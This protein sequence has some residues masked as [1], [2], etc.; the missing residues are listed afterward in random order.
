MTSTP[1]EHMRIRVLNADSDF[2]ALFSMFYSTSQRI[3]LY[4]NNSFVDPANAEYNENG[5]M[6][7]IEPTQANLNS[8]M[9]TLYSPTGTNFFYKV[10][11]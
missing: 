6:V 9:P 2:K 5:D 7:L 3:D 4:S 10:N 1:P 8:F 11:I